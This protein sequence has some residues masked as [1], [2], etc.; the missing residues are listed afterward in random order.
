MSRALL[1]LFV[2][3]AGK[4]VLVV[5]GGVVAERKAAELAAAGAAVR[6]VAPDVT[7]A[8]RALA[9]A[10]SVAWDGRAFEDDDVAGAWLVVA[11]TDRPE[12]QKRVSTAADRARIFCVA[13]DDPSNA[14]AY[15]GAVI[16]R[17]PVTV[18]IS[19]SG[20]APA[21]ARLLREIFEQALPDD[22]FI[23]TARALRDKWK[24][25]ATPMASR[26]AEL[27]RAFKEKAG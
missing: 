12:V 26:F 1:P 4:D 2:D 21:L 5:G 9:D 16:R 13:V 18:A 15:G 24:R 11:A 27:V 3:V 14:S 10:G 7:D 6:V 25:E 17:G 22:A 23:D 20:E 8:L 19:T